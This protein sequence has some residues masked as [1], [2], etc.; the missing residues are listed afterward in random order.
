MP[1]LPEVTTTANKLNKILPGLKITSIWTNYD[2]P[3]FYGKENIK[4]PKYFIN[5][6]KEIV[7]TRIKSSYRVGKNVL[8]DIEGPRTIL[9]HMKMTGHVLYGNY[10][11]STIE[12]MSNGKRQKVRGWIP[13]DKGPLQDKFNQYIRLVFELSN[14]KFLVLS[15][16]RRFAKVCLISDGKIENFKDLK[17]LGP[18]PTKKEFNFKIFKEILNKKPEGRIKNVLMEQEI[19]SGI[20]NIYS[21]EALWMTGIHP[22]ENP[23]KLTDNEMKELLK[24]IKT[25]LKKGIDFGG[26]ST[27]DYRQPDGTPGNFQK[28][29]KVYRRKGQKCLLPKCSGKIIRLV[30][31]GRSAHFCDTHQKL[32][33]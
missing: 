14:G 25:I 30:V 23:K 6:K 19:I 2:S 10:K 32:K 13:V 5:F 15:D 31:G 21:D 22:E 3:Y 1:E 11:R 24:N 33:K 9:I 12:E 18:D 28:H 17:D 16:A 27:S 8:I 20:G 29:H 26:D 4:D 7:G